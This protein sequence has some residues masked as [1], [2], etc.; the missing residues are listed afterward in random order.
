M[1]MMSMMM[2]MMMIVL[3]QSISIGQE[4]AGAFGKMLVVSW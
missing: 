3:R 2:M 1:M 4:E